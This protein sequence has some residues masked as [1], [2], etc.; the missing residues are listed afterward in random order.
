MTPKSKAL[1][2]EYIPKIVGSHA[3]NRYHN[4]EAHKKTMAEK[5]ES[6]KNWGKSDGK[7]VDEADYQRRVGRAYND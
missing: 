7:K 4:N 6:R 3:Y 2:K 1:K 5:A